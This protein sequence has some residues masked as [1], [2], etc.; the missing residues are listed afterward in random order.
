LISNLYW[1]NLF[2]HNHIFY[3]NHL[4]VKSLIN[5]QFI[6]KFTHFFDYLFNFLI[7]KKILLIFHLFEII[8]FLLIKCLCSYYIIYKLI[9]T[10]YA[11]YTN[12]KYNFF[13]LLLKINYR[14][15]NSKV[16]NYVKY[17]FELFLNSYFNKISVIGS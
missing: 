4:L 12:R 15:M 10:N 3:K 6:N 16:Y 9:L 11:K 2:V 17:I 13:L 1:P 8:Y 14:K 7:T 5:Q